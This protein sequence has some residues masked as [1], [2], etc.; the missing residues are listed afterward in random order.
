MSNYPEGVT[1]AHPH[2]NPEE[3]AVTVACEATSALVV[4][5]FAVKAALIELAE[6]LKAVP[7]TTAAYA[8]SASA[9]RKGALAR[10]EQ[11]QRNI[12]EWEQESDYECDHEGEYE[13]PLSEAAEFDCE[14]CGHTQTVDTLPG[15]QDPDEAY[16]RMLE[17]RRDD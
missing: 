17:A 11:L 7:T 3:C 10:V 13:L 12:D 1:D 2:F 16:D 15:E 5:S 4:P 6:L 14:V 9:R 8:P